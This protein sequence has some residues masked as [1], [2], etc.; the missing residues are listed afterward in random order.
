MYN[1]ED[2]ELAGKSLG[3]ALRSVADSKAEEA[4]LIGRGVARSAK[5][6]RKKTIET[7]KRVR[8]KT[9][10]TAKSLGKKA[11]RAV[12]SRPGRVLTSYGQDAAI[13]FGKMSKKHKL[14]VPKDGQRCNFKLGLQEKVDKYP[15]KSPLHLSL[16]TYTC[17]APAVLTMGG[18]MHFC[19]HHAQN[20]LFPYI[21]GTA[22]NYMLKEYF[23]TVGKSIGLEVPY[24]RNVASL[25][26]MPVEII[27]GEKPL[28]E[29]LDKKIT[30]TFKV[31]NMKVFE[32]LVLG[33]GSDI[34]KGKDPVRGLLQD[35]EGAVPQAAGASEYYK[36][37]FPK[38]TKRPST[39]PRSNR[40]SYLT[41]GGKGRL[42][43][44]K[45]L[46]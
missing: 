24:D 22:G 19:A 12:S 27:T 20:K 2:F 11:Y 45:S 10:K 5:R 17:G 44:A 37:L 7:A 35:V 33:G 4:D 38:P 21:M 1:S 18:K 36:N 28:Q 14:E 25:N 42:S 6:V 40:T 30:T 31:T 46:Y 43:V 34:L 8:S 15:S 9:I 39:P 29:Q 32:R 3:R 16:N 23:R 13:L 41:G 26:K